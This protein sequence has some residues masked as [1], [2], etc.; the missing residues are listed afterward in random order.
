MQSIAC[1]EA[2][3]VCAEGGDDGR[4]RAAMATLGCFGSLFNLVLAIA[5]GLVANFYRAYVASVG[6]SWFFEPHYRVPPPPL[7]VIVVAIMIWQLL[8]NRVKAKRFVKKK[9]ADRVTSRS[10]VEAFLT[11]TF[12]TTTL[13]GILYLLHLLFPSVTQ[14]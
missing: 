7:V 4:H 3:P 11:M 1:D 2:C 12:V 9:K 13:W 6:W 14:H 5:L 10:L 8:T